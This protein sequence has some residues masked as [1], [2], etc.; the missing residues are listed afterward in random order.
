MKHGGRD[1]LDFVQKREQ[2]ILDDIMRKL[3]DEEAAQRWEAT[4]STIAEWWSCKYRLVPQPDR[5]SK[6]YG[7]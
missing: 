7:C 6:V 4:K 5:T 1:A 2:Q 3:E